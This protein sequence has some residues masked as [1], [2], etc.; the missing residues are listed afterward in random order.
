[1]DD[2][3]GGQT[4]LGLATRPAG[5]GRGIQGHVVELLKARPVEVLRKASESCRTLLFSRIG[6]ATIF[7]KQ[8]T[9]AIYEDLTRSHRNS[10]GTQIKVATEDFMT[11][12]E[13]RAL[14]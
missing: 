2:G 7:A 5:H 6:R 10:A 4:L 1:M 9:S 11:K 14:I 3:R 8:S 12:M 13:R